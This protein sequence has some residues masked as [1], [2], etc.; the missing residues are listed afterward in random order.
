M[1]KK[2]V[3]IIGLV[4]VLIVIVLAA[5]AAC[6]FYQNVHWW[7]K[8]MKKIEKLGVQEKQ[9]TLPSGHVINYGELEGDG[10]ALLLIHGQMVAWEEYASVIP[11]LSKNWHIYA[12]DLY[13][14][15]ESSHEEELYYLDVNG[16]DLIWFIENV[17]GEETVVSGHSNGA[18]LTA[19]IAANGGD[20][21]KGAVLEDPPVFSTQ[22]EGWETSF[23]YLDTYQPLHEYISSEQT[24]CWPAYYLRHC[25]WGQLFMKGAMPGLAKYA[26]HY[27]EK[28][29]GEEVKII[30]LPKSITS[31]FHYVEQYDMLYGEHFYD[32]TWNNGVTHEQMLSDIEVPCVYLHAKENSTEDGVYL[33][34]ASREQAER[35]VALI[36][37]HCRLIETPDSDHNIHGSHEDIYLEAVNS[38]LEERT[39][40]NAE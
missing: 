14:H 3:K 5:A 35:A 27:R 9:I 38:F 18:L 1:G 13:G 7:E 39:G 34:A 4:F 37:N 10:P 2:M 6:F 32:L 20:L 36:G 11:E 28:H 8:D 30:F 12:V 40:E 31:V 25:Y 19:Y 16:D 24:E 29:P 21:V 22:G 33:C 23:A 15:G 26:Q 17:I